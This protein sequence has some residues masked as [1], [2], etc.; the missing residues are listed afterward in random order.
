MIFE[1]A[2]GLLYVIGNGFFKALLSF[3]LK[4]LNTFL[5]DARVV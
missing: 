1:K 5:V 3:L 2:F 4:N